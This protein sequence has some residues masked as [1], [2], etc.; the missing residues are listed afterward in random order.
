MTR[1]C[2]RCSPATLS[3]PSWSP[4]SCSLVV[5]AASFVSRGR[6]VEHVVPPTLDRNSGFLVSCVATAELRGVGQA[7][8]L[9]PA[10]SH[11]GEFSTE[12]LLGYTLAS[13]GCLRSSKKRFG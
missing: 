12:S 1:R 10:G 9:M 11:F 2:R 4:L 7:P 5:S 6:F 8:P 3:R 13:S